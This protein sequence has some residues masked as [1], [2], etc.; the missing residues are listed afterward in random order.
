MKDRP[1]KFNRKSYDDNNQWAID[2]ITSFLENNGY[3]CPPKPE[4]YKADISAFKDGKEKL[5]EAETKYTFF[6]D[7]S[8]FPFPTVSFA[9]RKKKYGDFVYII[10]SKKSNWAIACESS[11]IYNDKFKEE[12][13]VNTSDRLGMDSFYR[14]PKELCHFFKIR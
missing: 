10:I 13:H 14:V 1:Q 2:I 4:D 3:D 11:V 7:E 12:V 5:F 6:E 9:A 8:T